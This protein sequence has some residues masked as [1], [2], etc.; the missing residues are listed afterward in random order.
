[1][2]KD[3]KT[4][5]SN[6]RTRLPRQMDVDEAARL[7]E[8]IH[9]EQSGA[10]FSLYFGN[11]TG[12]EL[13]AVSL[14]PERS[15]K[16]R[17]Q[18]LSARKLKAFILQ[19]RN[20]LADPRNSIGTWYKEESDTTYIDITATLPDRQLAVSLGWQYN[21][22]AVYDL[23]AEEE[24]DTGGSGEM[25]HITVQADQRLPQPIR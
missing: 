5:L 13:Y 4:Y 18:L 19:N 8:G 7:L 25:S 14:Y 6:R 1:M 21:Q 16:V 20:L 12:Q 2:A 24:I 10:T 17:G 3:L 22:I 15:V 23:A 9:N 11:V